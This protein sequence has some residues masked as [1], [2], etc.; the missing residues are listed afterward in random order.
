MNRIEH[1]PSPP[2]KRFFAAIW[3]S[4]REVTPKDYYPSLNPST[5]PF[6][7]RKDIQPFR[8]PLHMACQSKG[9]FADQS[10]DEATV[11]W[12]LDEQGSD[13]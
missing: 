6:P 8:T 2:G 3:K 9:T 12:L 13:W 5:S 1:H 11:A 10:K 4:N 7:I